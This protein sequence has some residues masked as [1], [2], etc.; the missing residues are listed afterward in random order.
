VATPH[1]VVLTSGLTSGHRPADATL[2]ARIDR[3]GRLTGW[4]LAAPLP[5]ARFHPASVHHGD[6]VYVLGALDQG[7]ASRTVFRARLTAA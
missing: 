7:R 1:A 6:H 3:S 5:G 4:R 2:V